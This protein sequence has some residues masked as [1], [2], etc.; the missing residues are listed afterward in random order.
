MAIY[1]TVGIFSRDGLKNYEWLKKF[2]VTFLGAENVKYFFI[3]NN[4]S[5]EFESKVYECTVAILYHTKKRGRVN[6]TN[7]TDSL[8]DK[9]LGHLSRVLGKSNVMVVIDDLEKSSDAEKWR[10]LGEQHS[11]DKLAGELFLFNTQSK[12]E[13]YA[14]NEKM[15]QIKKIIMEKVVYPLHE[16]RPVDMAYQRHININ[17]DSQ[18]FQSQSQT[19]L[20]KHMKWIMFLLALLVFCFCYVYFIY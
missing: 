4:N 11:V 5:C 18:D 10:I 6:I 20:H 1:P 13:H 12:L 2:L 7:V 3:T 19:D 14:N 15:N 16:D 9:E 17:E 8:Y